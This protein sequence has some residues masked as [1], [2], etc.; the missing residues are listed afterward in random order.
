M[1]SIPIT[2][3]AS[4]SFETFMLPRY[5]VR[6][7]PERP[8]TIKEVTS[9]IYP[10]ATLV[11]TIPAGVTDG[12]YW[13]DKGATVYGFSLFSNLYTYDFFSKRLHGVDEKIDI[14]SLAIGFSF[15]RRLL[16]KILY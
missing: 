14:E 6:A 4:I 8:I 10:N 13:R 2:S 3:K 5:V 12:R 1:G 9:D 11:P 7:A 15:Y 16:K